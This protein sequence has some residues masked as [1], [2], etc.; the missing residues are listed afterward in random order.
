M[1]M[2]IPAVGSSGYFQL[3]TPFD[4]LI[5]NKER[6]T[7]QAVRKLSEYLANNETPLD[8]IYVANGLTP[9]QYEEDLQNDV[10]IVSLQAANGHWVYA[11]ATYVTQFPSVNG[12]PY[13]SV[14]IGVALPPLPADKDLSHVRTAIENLIADVLGVTCQTKVVETSKVVLVDT[15]KHTQTEA[16][17]TALAAGSGTDRSRYMQQLA[18]N[19]GLRQKITLLESYIEDNNN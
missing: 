1:S 7:C 10:Y 5:L 19:N 6:Y 11:P 16:Q 15:D 14:M 9:A 2:V 12:I 13:R 8:D 17:R 4:S 3:R 18:I